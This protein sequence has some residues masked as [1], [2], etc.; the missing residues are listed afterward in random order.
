LAADQDKPLQLHVQCFYWW[1]AERRNTTGGAPLRQRVRDLIAQGVLPDAPPD[2]Y[3]SKR[4]DAV[5][6]CIICGLRFV[7]G[8]SEYAAGGGIEL[9]APIHRDCLLLWIMERQ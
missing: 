9:V 8:E 6:T 3:T 1:D 2:R 7:T 4:S 5:A